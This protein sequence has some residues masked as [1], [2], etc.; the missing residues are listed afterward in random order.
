MAKQGWDVVRALAASLPGAEEGTSY[1]T[2]AFKV[3]G[4]LFA[5]LHPE[6]DLV[7]RVDPDDRDLL[8]EGEP[9]RFYTTDHYRGYDMML[10]RLDAISRKRL[11]EVLEA[12]WRRVAGKRRI[13][14]RDG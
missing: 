7:V 8:C 13:A 12:S 9:E 6:G 10:V 14:E 11:A 3:R 1:R 5:R 4:K 2:P